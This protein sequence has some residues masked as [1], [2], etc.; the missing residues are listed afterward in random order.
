[1]K[2]IL[3]YTKAHGCVNTNAFFASH[4]GSI[5]KNHLRFLEKIFP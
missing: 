1:M 5:H 4:F 2:L 3:N